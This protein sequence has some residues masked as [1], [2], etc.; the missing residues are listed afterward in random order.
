MNPL[1][2]HLAISCMAFHSLP[3]PSWHDGED[4][5]SIPEHIGMR[6]LVKRAYVHFQQLKLF[7]AFV[8]CSTS[9]SSFLR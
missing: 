4:E 6:T 2:R 7:V 9:S 3:S 8:V 5:V 1:E